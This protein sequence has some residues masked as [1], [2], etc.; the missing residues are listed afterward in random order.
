M[1]KLDI[2]K[3]RTDLGLTQQEFSIKI[4]V[5]T[6]TLSHWETGRTK[7]SKMAVIRLKQIKGSK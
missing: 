2:K 3:I 5:S 4:P 6:V 1:D 7:P